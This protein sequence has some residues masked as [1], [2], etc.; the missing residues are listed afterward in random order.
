MRNNQPVTA[1][2]IPVAED[3]LL[4]SRTDPDSRIV[5]ANAAF[6]EI[7]GFTSEELLGQPHNLVRHPDM[8]PA[9]FADMWATLKAGRPW[10]GLVKNRTKSGDFYWVR[11]NVT[12]VVEGGETTGYISI[13]GRPSR[14]E[15]AE[16]EAA[17][18]AMRAGR[19]SH[20]VADG[21]LQRAGPVARLARAS[22]AIA[23]RLAAAFLLMIAM[24][25]GTGIVT[26]TGMADSNDALHAMYEDRAVPIAQLAEISDLMRTN[27]GLV[28]DIAAGL[29]GGRTDGLPAQKQAILAN[30]DRISAVWAEY[31]ATTLTEEE[32]GIAAAYA[33]KR[34]AFVR[35]GLEAGIALAERGEQAALAA[36][37]G[38]RLGALFGAAH[39]EAKALIGLQT[40]VARE[41]NEAA[42]GDFRWHM[43]LALALLGVAVVASLGLGAWLLGTIR[44]PLRGLQAHFT[45]IGEGDNTRPIPLPAAGEFHGVTRMLR[46]MRARLLYAQEEK[47]QQERATA[48]ERRAAVMTMAATVEQEARQAVDQVS[49]STAQM[50]VQTREMSASAAR[51]SDNAVSVAAA[52]EQALANAQAVSAASEELSAS[53]SEIAGQVAQAGAV[54]QRAVQGGALAQERIRSLSES[55]AKIGDVVQLISSIAGQTNL[56]ALN[57]TIEAARAGDAGKGFAVVASEVKNLATQ[58]A[59]STEEIARQIG[60]IQATTGAVVEAVGEISARITEL[61]QV[62]VAVAAA[63]EQQASATQEITRNVTQTGLAAQ[64]VSQRIAEVSAEAA[65]SGSQAQSV[66][67]GT[68]AVAAVLAALSGNIV[69]AIRTA[70]VDAERRATPRHVIDRPCGVAMGRGVRVTARLRDISRTGARIE[71]LAPQAEGARGT[72]FVDSLGSEC[73]AE[74]TLAAQDAGGSARLL[75]VEGTL[76]PALEAALERLDAL[77][78]AKAA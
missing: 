8:P 64:E 21:E 62:S 73:R 53:I 47:L 10:D 9:A 31:M 22:H 71:G 40:R 72:I 1:T 39:D 51:V 57:A 30:R 69:R 7:S 75:L 6:T 43:A 3:H 35:D 26:L 36:H 29:E 52:A 18:A 50:A 78:G 65:R 45:A 24:M 28:R 11:A 5:F 42:E 37:V 70:T 66:E 38:G 33:A 61:A 41:M 20:V 67:Q 12:P 4:V 23:F 49:A 17:Y 54:A 13:R 2:E 27:L 15:V 60:E 34:A 48:R 76:S 14:A 32:K 55:A 44:R 59:R 19:P 25:V 56:L 68:E 77:A 16:A 58:T 46:A 74:F 63:V